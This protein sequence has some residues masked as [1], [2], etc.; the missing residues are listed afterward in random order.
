VCTALD[1]C[2]EAGECNPATGVCSNPNSLAGKP[3]GSD[4]DTECTS[5]DTCDGAGSCQANDKP[6]GTNC[7]D[8]GTECTNQDKCNG[9]GVCTDNGFKAAG[10]ACGDA[11]SNAC[12]APDTCDGSGTCQANNSADGTACN[13]GNA[14]TT[15]DTCSDGAC[16]GGPVP[17]CDDGNVC[18]DDSCNPDT[19]CVHVNNTN[20]CDD[21]NSCTLTDTCQAGICTGASY[22]WSGVLQPIN[23]DGTSIF[24]YGSTVPTKFKLTGPCAGNGALTFKIFV[25]KITNRVQGTEIE[26][27]ST[28]AADTGNTFR[29]TGDQYIFNLATKGLAAGTWQIRIAQ[30]QGS[31]ELVTLGAV[32][33]SLKK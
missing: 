1:E 25:A 8:A 24:K 17:N 31:S 21:E 12:T 4:S 29:Y 15:N 28:S 23:A 27:T 14:C 2:H 5:P 20:P 19:G 9:A 26:A 18:T 22:S 13:D 6:T 16:V 11:T 33:I 3:C 10:T 30:Y 7:G 32:N